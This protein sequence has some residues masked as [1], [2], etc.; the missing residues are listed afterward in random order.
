LPENNHPKNFHEIFNTPQNLPTKKPRGR[1]PLAT[2]P[3]RSP[4]TPEVPQCSPQGAAGFGGATGG[5]GGANAGDLGDVEVG[6]C[7]DAPKNASK[8]NLYL[9]KPLFSRGFSV[10]FG[11]T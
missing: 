10:A 4:K 7:D 6:R 8:K 2:S 3:T 11:Y 5:L 1:C 9:R